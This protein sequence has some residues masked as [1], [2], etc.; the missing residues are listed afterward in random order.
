MRVLD[1]GGGNS[2]MFNGFATNIVRV[3]W[4]ESFLRYMFLKCVLQDF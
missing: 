1:V 2:M 3:G 4:F